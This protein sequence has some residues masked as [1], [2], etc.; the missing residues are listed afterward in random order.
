M[1]WI[2]SKQIPDTQPPQQGASEPTSGLADLCFLP[3]FFNF[4]NQHYFLQKNNQGATLKKLR[5]PLQVKRK[6]TLSTLLLL[7]LYHA[8]FFKEV[9]ILL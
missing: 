9:N 1:K 8:S 5:A 6:G 3:Y 7:Y 4:P 2:I